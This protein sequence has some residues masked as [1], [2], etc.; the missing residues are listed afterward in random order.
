[1]KIAA[2]DYGYNLPILKNL[3]K[4]TAL[5]EKY[6][7]ESIGLEPI[8]VYDKNSQRD[9]VLELAGQIYN[10]ADEIVFTY[11]EGLERLKSLAGSIDLLIAACSLGREASGLDLIGDARRGN[12]GETLTD[13]PIAVIA[14]FGD[15]LSPHTEL[16]EAGL[17]INLF[18]DYIFNAKNQDALLNLIN[19]IQQT[20]N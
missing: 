10:N 1:M 19:E 11:E 20:K 15:P 18:I 7:L 2:V 8:F 12:L 3:F 13:I 6:R 9:K 17:G 5:L 14:D 4:N 16:N